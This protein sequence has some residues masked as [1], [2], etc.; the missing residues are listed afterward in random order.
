MLHHQSPLSEIHQWA[1][2]T[3]TWTLLWP[4]SRAKCF[5]RSIQIRCL[6]CAHSKWAFSTWKYSGM[7]TL[8]GKDMNHKYWI[9]ALVAGKTPSCH[10]W[11]VLHTQNIQIKY[12][13]ATQ[14]LIRQQAM[15]T[16]IHSDRRD[17]T[18]MTAFCEV[19]SRILWNQTS[20]CD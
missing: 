12:L 1:S 8:T 3:K 4:S 14:T 16:N 18:L 15:Q 5:N 9:L 10:S 7:V 2:A 6:L 20:K 13:M 17:D 19:C 11:T